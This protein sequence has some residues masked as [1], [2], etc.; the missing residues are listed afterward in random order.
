MIDLPLV[1]SMQSPVWSPKH[2]ALLVNVTLRGS[3]DDP[4]VTPAPGGH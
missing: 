1:K 4:D 2:N 3:P